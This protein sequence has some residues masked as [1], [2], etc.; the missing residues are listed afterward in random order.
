MGEKY[1]YP[2]DQ[3]FSLGRTERMLELVMLGGNFTRGVLE[4]EEMEIVNEGVEFRFMYLTIPVWFF[5]VALNVV[6]MSMLLWEKMEIINQCMILDCLVSIV[7]SSLST[8]QQSPYYVGINLEL[9]CIPHMILL[10]SCM[11]SNRI[12]P[13]TIAFYR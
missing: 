4:T 6:V 3:L 2:F 9:Y 11:Q 13:I 12:L 8:F 1:S 10:S 5:T 7:Y